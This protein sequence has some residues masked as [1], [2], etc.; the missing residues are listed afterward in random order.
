M[1]NVLFECLQHILLVLPIIP[2]L[3]HRASVSVSGCVCLP[4][5][6]ITTMSTEKYYLLFLAV[7]AGAGA[8]AVV[9][10]I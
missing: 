1:G 6:G 10:V 7:E 9:I 5:A 4:S 2:V 8:I 3:C